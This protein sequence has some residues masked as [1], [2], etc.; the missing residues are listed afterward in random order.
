MAYD[1]VV[2]GL[3]GAGS[4]AAY[5]LARRGLRVLGLERFGPVHDRGSSHGHTRI[6]RQAYFE[7]PDY[8]PLLLRAYELWEELQQRVGTELLRV[9]GGLM[10]GPA[11]GALVSG[12]LRSAREYGL[13]HELLSAADVRAR[14]PAFRLAEDEQALYEPRA[15]IL[16]PEACV[17]AH[18]ELAASHG[19]QLRFHTRLLDWDSD[20]SRVRVRTEGGTEE[21]GRLVLA[22]GA[23]MPEVVRCPLGLSV[24]RQVVFWFRPRRPEWFTPERFPVFVWETPEGFFYG[25]PAVGGRGFKAARHHGGQT[26][27]P[28]RVPPARPEEA[29]WLR[30]QLRLRLPEADGELADAVTCL[31]TN[32]PD[33]HFVLDR[34][35]EFGNVVI[36][37]ACSGHGFKFTSVVGEVAAD[38]ATE[39]ASRL[40]VGFLS[41]RRFR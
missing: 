2:V 21:A 31:Y 6:T 37:S 26:V 27:H 41:L 23:W 24:E 14:F 20:G 11:T 3:G 28:D 36:C 10:V 9:C 13:P 7:H 16:F 17:R 5:H 30:T 15:G 12:A 38:L 19:A 29:G 32:T 33:E 35:P 25:I 8:V 34:H 40:P 4:S 18:Q 22:A 39:G 1:A